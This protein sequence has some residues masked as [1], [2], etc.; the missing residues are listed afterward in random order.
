VANTVASVRIEIGRT[1]HGFIRAQPI[2]TPVKVHKAPDLATIK[3][4]TVVSVCMALGPIAQSLVVARSDALSTFIR[5]CAVMVCGR[6]CLHCACTWH[7]PRWVAGGSSSCTETSA[8]LRSVPERPC[9]SRDPEGLQRTPKDPKV[10]QGIPRDSEEFQGN[11]R[12]LGG[13][14]GTLRDPKGFQRIQD[15]SG[16]QGTPS[17][18]NR[19]QGTLRDSKEPEKG[20]Q[21]PPR[22]PRDS[23]GIRGTPRDFNAIPGTSRDFSAYQAILKDTR[24]F[25]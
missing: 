19:F 5:V 4:C 14:Q 21:G 1:A 10:I 22:D 15:F 13:H 7:E 12:D 8:P 6:C 20:P 9:I 17:D 11:S 18:P 23:K 2:S 3:L 16:F 24:G 25:H